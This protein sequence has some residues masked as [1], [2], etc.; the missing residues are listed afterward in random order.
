MNLPSY[1]RGCGAPFQTKDP[2]R[3]G[4]VP[5]EAL[6]REGIRCQRCYRILHYGLRQEVVASREEYVAAIRRG[7][8]EAALVVQVFDIIDFEGSWSEEI[9]ALVGNKPLLAAVTKV[10]LLP[11]Q[12]GF[13]EVVKWCRDRLVE[14]G[15]EPVAV[16]PVSSTRGWGIKRLLEQ[17]RAFCG[18]QRTAV[19]VG[20][21]NVGKSSLLN[22]LRRRAG[23][24]ETLHRPCRQ[25]PTL[26]TSP[27]P[28]T[29]QNLVRVD[30][31]RAG[32]LLLDTPGLSQSGR[33]SDLLCPK[34][35][36]RLIPAGEVSRKTYKLTSDQ[37]LLF[38]GLAQF[39]VNG[40]NLR[41]ILVAF[42]ARGVV[43]HVTRKER[44]AYVIATHTGDWLAP[45]CSECKIEQWERVSLQVGVNRDVVIPGLGWVSI[46][47][48]PVDLEVA[49]PAGVK[50]LQ[51]PALLTPYRE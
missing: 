2:R 32:V 9:T 45:P 40:G 12:V 36:R 16:V 29:T 20:A 13:K 39:D 22:A 46:R 21:T 38:G 10:D 11:H 28:G 37:S 7:I 3:P 26:T 24:W 19:V 4:Y 50:V 42:A 35:N 34:C 8:G 43:F 17:I 5:P 23:E 51:R 30:L 15:R 48:G 49:V 33:L 47:R 41:P 18:L 31:P 6:G 44:A 25:S 14:L 27:Y 1:C